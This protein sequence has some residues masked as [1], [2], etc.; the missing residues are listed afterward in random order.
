MSSTKQI[1]NLYKMQQIIKEQEEM[2]K[3]DELSK[4]ELSKLRSVNQFSCCCL[5]NCISIMPI[6]IS[7]CPFTCMYNCCATRK[8]GYSCYPT[9]EY[10]NNICCCVFAEHI[11]D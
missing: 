7:L 1:E 2:I 11:N 10:P 8:I 4:I 5:L 9:K 3:N 6:C